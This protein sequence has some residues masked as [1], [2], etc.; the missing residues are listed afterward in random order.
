VAVRL[1]G[2]SGNVEGIGATVRVEPLAGEASTGEVST[3]EASAGRV[4]AGEVVPAQTKE[5]VAGGQ[6]LS[7]SAAQVAFAV[8]AA[9]SVRIAVRWPGGARSVVVG[10]VNRLYE[11]YAPSARD[12]MALNARP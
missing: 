9:D 2:P 6:Y 4:S 10:G 1:R 8:G 5:V 7:D 3:G 12:A 11:I